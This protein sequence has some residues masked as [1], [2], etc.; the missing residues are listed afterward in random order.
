MRRL[1]AEPR[2]I[3]GLLFASQCPSGTI[4]LTPY[5]MLLDSRVSRAGPM[6]FCLSCSIPTIV[7]YYFPFSLL[8]V[9]RLVL[10][11]WGLRTFMVT[12]TL[13]LPTSLN[14]NNNISFLIVNTNNKY[15]LF[16]CHCKVDSNNPH[17]D[18]KFYDNASHFDAYIKS[19]CK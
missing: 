13:A 7:F 17:Y 19:K 18:Y 3:A 2:S 9:Y 16:Y 1:D 11:G 4:L 5:S 8:S 12:F 6:F 10:W 14:N 15:S